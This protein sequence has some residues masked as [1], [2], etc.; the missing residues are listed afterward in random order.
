MKEAE[1]VMDA[2]QKAMSDC[3][4]DPDEIA[5]WSDPRVVTTARGQRIVTNTN[6][7]GNSFWDAWKSSKDKIKDAG[8]SVRKNED[9]WQLTYWADP[10]KLGIDASALSD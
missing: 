9:V 6:M 5:E 10:A 8:F 4:L 2:L 3:G 7:L 1:L